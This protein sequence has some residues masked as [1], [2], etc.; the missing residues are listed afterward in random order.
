VAYVFLHLLPELS[1]GHDVLAREFG[2]PLDFIERHIYLISLVGL[3][4]FY[5]L[6]RLAKTSRR[7]N[8]SVG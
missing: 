6:E 4:A 3:A 8:K 1:S 7:Q 5:C 2:K